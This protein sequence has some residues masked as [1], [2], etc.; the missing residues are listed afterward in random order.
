[1]EEELSFTVPSDL[2]G[3]RLDRV[4]ATLGGMS[5][6]RARE[7][8]D[9]GL[10]TVNGERR[11]RR[12]RLAAGEL[13]RFPPPLP[14]PGLTPEEVPFRVRHLDPHLAVIE[15]PA[16]V[17]VHPGAGR[18]A[19]TVAAGLL[20][21]FP[22]IEGVGEEGRWGIVHR[23]DRDT[24]GLMVVALTPACYGELKRMVAGREIEREYLALVDGAFTVPT[25]TVDAPIARHPHRPGRRRV[26]PAGRPARTHYRLEAEFP[27]AG[28]SLVRI[29]LETG[30]T[31]QIRVHMAA[32][33]H[34]LCGDRVY[35]PGPDRI[36]TP[37]LFLHATRLAFTHPITGERVD[38]ESPL[39]AELGAVLADL[40]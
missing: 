22:S 18:R 39:P 38:V 16:G 36:P 7:M 14:E 9:S 25:G 23:L 11:E 35:R 6:A 24:S 31:H 3:E 20:A 10:V 4:V 5:R 33:G 26:D 21:R 17:V 8:V 15:K 40:A 29:R 19:G 12:A 13:V 37:R 28:M 32:I 30:R 27:Q 34:P 1:V 2:D